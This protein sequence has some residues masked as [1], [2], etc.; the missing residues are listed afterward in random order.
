MDAIEGKGNVIS[1][2]SQTKIKNFE[3]K[4]KIKSLTCRGETGIVEWCQKKK[5][6]TGDWGVGEKYIY[7]K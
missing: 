1:A 4:E 2:T 7:I 5:K 3:K 6:W